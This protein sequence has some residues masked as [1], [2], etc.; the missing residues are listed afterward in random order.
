VLLVGVPAIVLAAGTSSAPLD[1]TPAVAVPVAPSFATE[2]VAVG[3]GPYPGIQTEYCIGT[4]AAT[5]VR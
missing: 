2:V 5:M 3:C 1:P 4:T